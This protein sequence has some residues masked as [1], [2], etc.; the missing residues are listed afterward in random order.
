MS[1]NNIIRAWKDEEYRR[2]L[3]EAERAVLPE[4]PGGFVDLGDADLAVIQ[5]GMLNSWVCSWFFCSYDPCTNA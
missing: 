2:S 1:H 4:H 5:G 3:T